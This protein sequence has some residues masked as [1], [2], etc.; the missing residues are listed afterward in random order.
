SA[1]SVVRITPGT[2]VFTGEH[3]TLRCDIQG[4]GG[5]QWI[6]SWNKNKI[7]MRGRGDQEVTL[8]S[9]TQ[10]DSGDY[11]C[12]GQSFYSQISDAV[13]LTVS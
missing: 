1:K 10:S 12:R 4:R 2:R 3:V 7:S 9:V 11:T 6:Y 8:S 13:T 5:I